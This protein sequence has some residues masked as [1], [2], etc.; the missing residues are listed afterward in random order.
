MIYLALLLIWIIVTTILILSLK[1][2]IQINLI[3]VLSSIYNFIVGFFGLVIYFINIIII[4][5]IFKDM[6][7]IEFCYMLSGIIT[8]LLLMI[9]FIPM[10]MKI[11]EKISVNKNK[12]IILSVF[13]M[14]LGILTFFILYY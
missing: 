6:T 12:Y 13:I 1:K 11:K 14:I 4:L 9:V 10:N 7:A 2:G 5:G 8:L 3:I